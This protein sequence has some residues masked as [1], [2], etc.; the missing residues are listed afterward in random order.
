MKPPEIIYLQDE[1]IEHSTYEGIT[2]SKD[3]I[4]KNDTKYV[5]ADLLKLNKSKNYDEI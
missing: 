1:E 4:S 3:Q 2:W 5:R